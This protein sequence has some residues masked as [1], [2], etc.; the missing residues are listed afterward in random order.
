MSSASQV[1][2][3]WIVDACRNEEVAL[4]AGIDGDVWASTETPRVFVGQSG[5]IGA[6]NRGRLPFLE[7]WLENTQH[8]NDTGLGG[9]ILTTAR[10]R[11]HDTGRDQETVSNRMLATLTAC[12]AEVRANRSENYTEL[13]DSSIEDIQPGPFGW[14]LDAKMDFQHSYDRADFEVHE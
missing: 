11:M 12:I 9:T 1:L 8:V 14:S 4:W 5:Y 7:V 3:E 2:R 13:G 10:I 6:R